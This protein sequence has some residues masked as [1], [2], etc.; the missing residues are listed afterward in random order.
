[1][2]NLSRITKYIKKLSETART[3]DEKLKFLD[4]MNGFIRLIE[5]YDKSKNLF[6]D[7]NK[8]ETP[9]HNLLK[10]YHSLQNVS[11][12]LFPS[13]L[14]DLV[15]LSLNGGLGTTMGLN[16]AKSTIEVKDGL[17]F[18]DIT[19]RQIEDLN[20]KYNV[21]VPLVLMNSFNTHEETLKIIQKYKKSNVQILCFNQHQY[22]RIM[23]ES[24]TPMCKTIYDSNDNWYPPGHGDVYES[25]V[26]SDVFQI[27]LNMGKKY[28][29]ISNI[30][31]LGATV[32]L[33]IL[34]DLKETDVDF[35]MELT[36]KTQA[37]VKGGTLIQ[38]DGRPKLLEIAQCPQNKLDE[39]KSIKK[40]KIFNTNNLWITMRGLV[41]LV[42]DNPCQHMDII[43][44]SKDVNGKKIIQLEQASAAVISY[45]DKASAI[46]VP[47]KR[48]IPVKTTSDLFIIQS[49]IYSLSNY[50]LI[51]NP[52]RPFET[53]PLVK[54]GEEFKTI[55][56][57][58]N[59]FKQ[60]PDLL[61]LHHLTVSG[62]VV[63]NFNVKLSGTVIIIANK[64]EHIDIPNNSLLEDKI[65]TGSLRIM[66]H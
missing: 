8:I 34:Y 30:D 64:N 12:E 10:D 28:I 49:N 60:L 27:L 33:N 3:E 62:D 1:M 23:K 40:F 25:L 7:W 15:V 37:D 14:N 41:N 22:P 38:Y 17:T 63:F 44:N 18:L 46:V 9:S 55:K 45:F 39:F 59:R 52:Q 50:N 24:M 42:K 51:I 47:R 56:D 48:Y 65:V 19:V 16:F 4:D 31:N 43:I 2:T 57:Y 26:K 36:L 13:L 66:D 58:N 32:D 6:L 54:L 5:F 11:P 61:N 21:S 20:N 29:F 35:I 53:L